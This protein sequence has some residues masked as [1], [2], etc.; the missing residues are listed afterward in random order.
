MYQKK[1][2]KF[3]EEIEKHW[4]EL[5]EYCLKITRQSAISSED[6]F[7]QTCYESLKYCSGENEIDSFK[8]FFLSRA[9]RTY[10]NMIE[11]EKGKNPEKRKLQSKS[12]TPNDAYVKKRRGAINQE[13]IEIMSLSNLETITAQENVEDLAYKVNQLEQKEKTALLESLR[14]KSMER[15]GKEQKTSHGT[16]QRRRQKALKQLEKS[17]I[18]IDYEANYN[19]APTTLLEIC[20]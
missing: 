1:E 19:L 12:I 15:I 4:K 9:R 18:G 17:T 14:G 6:L 5:T 8:G 7:Q 20:T 16:I 11:R 10:L 13:T 3:E 2:E